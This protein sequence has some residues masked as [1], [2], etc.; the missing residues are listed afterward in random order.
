[1]AD[2]E[3]KIVIQPQQDEFLYLVIANAA[4]SL[5]VITYS[6]TARF[7]QTNSNG[8]LKSNRDNIGNL[9]AGKE[10]FI[11]FDGDGGFEWRGTRI[12]Q[13]TRTCALGLEKEDGKYNLY[14]TPFGVPLC[15]SESS[16]KSLMKAF[17]DAI[18]G[19]KKIEKSEGK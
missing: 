3:F 8:H 11:E 5:P 4:S 19:E 13:K 10:K 12:F 6:I 15:I 9:L 7:G 16:V 17:D 18:N 2:L 1:M 14:G